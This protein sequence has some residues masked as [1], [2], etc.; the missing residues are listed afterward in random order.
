MTTLT[1]KNIPLDV[2]KRLKQRAKANR[3]SMNQEVIAVIERALDVPPLDVD[4]TLERTR[5]IRELTAQYRLRDEELELWK[6]E[7]R[8]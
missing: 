6:N 2:Y 1:I 4:T 3:R 8:K 5:K 7:G